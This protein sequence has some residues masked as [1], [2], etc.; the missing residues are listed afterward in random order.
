MTRMDVGMNAATK[1]LDDIELRQHV[2]MLHVVQQIFKYV[3]KYII[4]A[5]NK[6][7]I[8]SRSLQPKGFPA[9]MTEVLQ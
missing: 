7:Y 5:T 3:P 1:F 6:I 9:L 4:T 8:T 2:P